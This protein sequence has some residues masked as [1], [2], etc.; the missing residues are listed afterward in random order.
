MDNKKNV[1]VL[2][3]DPDF[4]KIIGFILK[5]MNLTYSEFSNAED[6]LLSLK[7]EEYPDVLL[8]DLNLQGNM[9]EGYAVI[10]AIRNKVQIP[11][12][13][14]AASRRDSARDIANVF[15]SGADD[16]IQKPIDPLLLGNKLNRFLNKIPVNNFYLNKISSR[17]SSAKIE[18]DLDLI[19]VSRYE[20]VFK[21]QHL[22]SKRTRL[23]LCGAHILEI[24]GCEE[25]IVTVHEN[26]KDIENDC[27]EITTEVDNF[28]SFKEEKIHLWM[29]T[30]H[31]E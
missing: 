31:N 21:T 24:T 6:L 1:Y 20:F 15:E 2:D 12:P 29:K 16:Y 3:D 19:S 8:I 17:K 22:I 11:L 30:K 9:G 14:I 5:K 4:L 25:I 18:F 23:T 27:Y 10:K 26:K 7:S 13:I 28:D